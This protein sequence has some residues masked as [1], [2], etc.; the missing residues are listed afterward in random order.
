MLTAPV[1]W[2]IRGALLRRPVL[3]WGLFLGTVTAMALVA[4]SLAP[5]LMSG[6]AGVGPLQVT[7]QV[8]MLLMVLP[9]AA[10][11]GTARLGL[12]P[13]TSPRKLLVLL[14]PALTVAY[15]FSL[16]FREVPLETLVFALLSVALA[17]TVEELAFRGVLLDSLAPRGIWR[18]VA[19]SS[20]LF[21]LMHV[22]NLFL[23]APWFSVLLQV[24]FAGMAGTGY[25]AMRL[26]TR[27]L[28][29]PIILH[30]LFD[31][32]FRVAVVQPGSLFANTIQ[33]L[34]GVGWLIFALIVLR[35]SQRADIEAR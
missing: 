17:G 28:W 25:A 14:F 27:S 6:P 18:A 20:A 33:M 7:L 11:V 15:G 19:L 4:K 16:G 10:R 1:E 8:L 30:A 21:G 13:V 29:P 32:T 5:D 9:F 3:L 22:T 12:V 23:G 35:P 24:T 26:R 31:L 2:S 34:H